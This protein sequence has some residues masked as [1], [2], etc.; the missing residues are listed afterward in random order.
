[1][2]EQYVILLCEG[3]TTPIAAKMDDV[4]D[5][6]RADIFEKKLNLAMANEF[7]RLRETAQIENYLANT[8]HK[9]AAAQHESVSLD[10]GVQPAGANQPRMGTRPTVN[11]A[12]PGQ[13]KPT[14]APVKLTPA[15]VNRP[16]AK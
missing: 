12:A 8:S 2:G 16:A 15:P 10:P 13:A 4:K 6:L 1:M 9:P 14:K 11:A 3:H 7:D 5:L